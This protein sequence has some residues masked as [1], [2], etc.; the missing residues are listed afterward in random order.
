MTLE[1]NRLLD[2]LNATDVTLQQQ[3]GYTKKELQ[4]FARINQIELHNCKELITPG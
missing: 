4:D 2:A 1:Y 3:R